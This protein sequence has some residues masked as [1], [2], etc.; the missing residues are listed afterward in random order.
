MT[1]NLGIVGSVPASPYRS[2]KPG[3]GPGARISDRAIVVVHIGPD[4]LAYFESTGL[5]GPRAVFILGILDV[6]LGGR[7]KALGGGFRA[8]RTFF[9]SSVIDTRVS[10]H[11]AIVRGALVVLTG[12][13]HRVRDTRNAVG[14]HL[15]GR[16]AKGHAEC[17]ERNETTFCQSTNGDPVA[18]TTSAEVL[19][20]A[21]H[22]SSYLSLRFPHMRKPDV[23]SDVVLES[24]HRTPFPPE[25]S[26]CVKAPCI[27]WEAIR[28]ILD[29]PGTLSDL[30]RKLPDQ[31]NNGYWYSRG[32]S[33]RFS[34]TRSSRRARASPRHHLGH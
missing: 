20:G 29:C 9:R 34:R 22:L 28:L 5:I 16:R 6:N 4:G 8:I 15:R 31:R 27:R 33:P 24:V 11:I 17:K 14:P 23:G 10:N 2:G 13:L 26:T 12:P 1:H 21:I 25:P 3:V 18:A 19:V 30:Q 32:L 7:R